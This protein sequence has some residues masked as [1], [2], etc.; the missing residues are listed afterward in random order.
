MKMILTKWAYLNYDSEEPHDFTLL[1]SKEL[2]E[3]WE[4]HSISSAVD[5]H[6]G[7]PIMVLTALLL[8]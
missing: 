7:K 5:S 1:F 6:C 8:K 3:G 4:I 2:D